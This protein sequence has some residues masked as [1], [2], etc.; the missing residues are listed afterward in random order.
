MLLETSMKSFIRFDTSDGVPGM[1]E[2]D[3]VHI[4]QIPLHEGDPEGLLVHL[5]SEEQQRACR[6]RL[7]RVRWQFVRARAG[8]RTVL[9][10]YLDRPAADVP[11]RTAPTGRPE[12]AEGCCG[13]FDFNLTHSESVGLVAVSCGGRVGVD[14]ER[15]RVIA[16][17]DNL[18]RRFF[19][20][21][22]QDRFF[23]LD[24]ADRQEAFFQAWTRKEA[25]LKAVGRGVASLD[26]CEV[27]FGP[28][29]EAAV[30]RLE[31]DDEAHL[32]WQMHVWEPRAG[33][34][35]AAVAEKI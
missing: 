27:A 5:T 33:Y 7:D 25:I 4:W 35:A 1:P 10:G 30:L 8:L 14:V 19:A 31:G 16:E 29:A 22:E 28:G 24:A 6:L 34:R 3:E 9:G 17:R 12:L 20:P 2:R 18:V 26:C 23:G 11:I 32:R 21:A 13:G 15:V